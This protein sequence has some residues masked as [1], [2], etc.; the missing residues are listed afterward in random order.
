[1]IVEKCVKIT[2]GRDPRTHESTSEFKNS[3]L[4][5]KNLPFQLKQEKLEEMLVNNLFLNIFNLLFYL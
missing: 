1:V 3:T 4:V 2:P 5:F